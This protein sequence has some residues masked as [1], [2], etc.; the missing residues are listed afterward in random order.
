MLSALLAYWNTQTRKEKLFITVIF[1]ALIYGAY[2][3][4]QNDNYRNKYYKE[5]EGKYN[6]IIDS[7]G[8]I[9]KQ[10]TETID[11]GVKNAIKTKSRTK[12]IN[13]KLKQD[14]ASI[15]ST[16]VSSDRRTKFL[17]GYDNY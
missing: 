1:L 14:E 17:A 9:N 16:D 11:K 8:S 10:T 6:R 7:I 15:D 13:D 2:W 5:L 12:K 3:K 4:L